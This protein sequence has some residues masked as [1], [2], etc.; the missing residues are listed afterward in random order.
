MTLSR[1]LWNL[2]RCVACG[3]QATH[4]LELQLPVGSGLSTTVLVGWCERHYGEARHQPE[5]AKFS[6]VDAESLEPKGVG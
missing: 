4:V 2:L 5:W 3:Q 6:I 1:E